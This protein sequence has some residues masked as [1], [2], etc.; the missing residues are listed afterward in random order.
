M[1]SGDGEFWYNLSTHEV[2]RGK[3]SPGADRAGPF[4]T[5]EEAARAPQILVERSRQW[6]EDEEHEDEWGTPPSGGGA[7]Q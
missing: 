3:Q 5:A 2:E 1:T 6:Q 4:A 7:R